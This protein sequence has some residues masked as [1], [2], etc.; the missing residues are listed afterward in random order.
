MDDPWATAGTDE[1]VGRAGVI[2]GRPFTGEIMDDFACC[3]A[4]A[5]E[6]TATGGPVG[7]GLEPVAISGAAAGF[8][9][10]VDAAAEA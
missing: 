9:L 10:A 4:G 2:G 7:G 1:T 8:L 5:L 3:T 6:P